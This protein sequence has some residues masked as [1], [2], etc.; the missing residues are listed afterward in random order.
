MSNQTVK[1]KVHHQP[2]WRLRASDVEAFVTETGGHV[3]PVTFDRRGQRIRPYSIAPWAGER[4]DRSMPPII[5]VLRGDFF[6]MPFG[7]NEGSFR[8]ERHLVHGEVANDKWNFESLDESNGKSTL[9]LSMQT[10]VRKGRVDKR[11]SLVDG[12]SAVYCQHVISKMSGPMDFGHHAMLKFPDAEGS[13]VISTS[14]LVYGQVF[15]GNFEEPAER[16]YSVLKPG[17]EFKSLTQV[18]TITG[19]MADLTRFPARRGWEDLV[20][21]M[22]NPDATVAWTAVTF[23]SERYVWFSLKNPRMLSGT[24]FWMS[25]GGRHYPPW[26]GRHVNVMALEDVTSYFHLG[27]NASAMKNPLTE[28]GYRTAIR[29]DPRR[30][31]KINYIMAAAPIPAGF[32]RVKRMNAKADGVRLIADSGKTVEV[33][34]NP[35]FLHS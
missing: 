18:P 17:A 31:V 2:S 21:V 1:K 34:L 27:I 14:K 20:Q 35:A 28:K 13:G 10:T 11:I 9:H 8:G 32:D 25:N 12:H 15:P 7:A 33:P 16:G 3:G 24:I 26:N 22:N 6:C 23:P 19:E 5:R 4:I 29:L 30:S